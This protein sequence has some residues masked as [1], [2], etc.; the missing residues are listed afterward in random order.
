MNKSSSTRNLR[1]KLW[2]ATTVAIVHQ[3]HTEH[4]TFTW[5]FGLRSLQLINKKRFFSSSSLASDRKSI[6]VEHI[7][8]QC[9]A[10]N[11][12]SPCT[13]SNGGAALV[14][15]DQKRKQVDESFQKVMYLSCWGVG[16]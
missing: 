15:G 16:T 11:G 13:I 12:L 1:S 6:G 5:N 4:K 7:S 10:I 3:C 2:M 8:D 9:S 14:G